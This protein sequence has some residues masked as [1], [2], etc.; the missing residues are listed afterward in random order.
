MTHRRRGLT[1]IELTIVVLIIG[2]TAAVAAPRFAD[3]VRMSKLRSVANQI[4][5]HVDYIRAVAVNESRSTTLYCDDIKQSYGSDNVNFPE[6]PG[7]VLQVAVGEQF[8]S[9]FKLTAN[10]DSQS[11]LAFDFEGV[12]WVGSTPL[13]SGTITIGSGNQGYV[14]RIAAGTGET[15]IRPLL[16][17]ADVQGDAS[18]GSFLGMGAN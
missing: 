11:K 6:R 3:S 15:T 1:L 18:G 4:A 14:I 8:D 7:E 2:I 16:V 10:F 17:S 5:S 13:D 9:S 12:P